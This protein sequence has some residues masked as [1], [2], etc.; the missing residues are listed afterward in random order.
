MKKMINE[1][2]KP[3]WRLQVAPILQTF[4][5]GLIALCLVV[6]VLLVFLTFAF[7]SDHE[8]RFVWPE[9]YDFEGIVEQLKR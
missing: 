3:F 9:S 7:F 6:L 1:Y 2:L 5:Y 4:A 8:G